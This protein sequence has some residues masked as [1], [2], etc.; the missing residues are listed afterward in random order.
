MTRTMFVGAAIL[1]AAIAT[2][3]RMLAQGAGV[4]PPGQMAVSDS[5]FMKNAAQD[6]R[7]EVALAE[8]AQRTSAN[9]SVKTFAMHLHDDHEKANAELTTL[10]Q[11]KHVV[12][13]TDVNAVQKSTASKLEKMSGATFDRA[14]MSEM[15]SAHKNAIDLFTKAGES[16]DSDVKAFALKTLPTLKTHLADAQALLKTVSASR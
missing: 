12:L 1:A 6:G 5:T 4:P 16:K 9:A 13:P 15:V 11:S 14:Y 3:P 8:L 2:A 10:A 7:A